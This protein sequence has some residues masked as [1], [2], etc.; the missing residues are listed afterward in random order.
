MPQID[1]QH[2]SQLREIAYFLWIDEGCPEGRAEDHW[3]LA[4]GML[5]VRAASAPEEEAKTPPPVGKA[6]PN[7]SATVEAPT[8]S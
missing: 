5:S 2:E 1:G 4:C 7:T 3:M 6:S 8:K